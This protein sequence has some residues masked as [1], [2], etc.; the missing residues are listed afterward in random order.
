LALSLWGIAAPFLFSRTRQPLL[1]ASIRYGILGQFLFVTLAAG[2]LI[3]GLVT[4]DF[5]IK[6][7]AFNTTRATPIY[8]RVTGLWGALEGSLLLWEWILII[9]SALVAWIYRDRHR[10]LMP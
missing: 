4:V 1:F 6:Y 9:F 10:E 3:Y 2:A 8:Y 5:S 7:V